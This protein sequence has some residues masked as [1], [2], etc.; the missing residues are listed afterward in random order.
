MSEPLT[1]RDDV[2]P[3]PEQ[4]ARA[5]VA[6]VVERPD[7]DLRPRRAA[8]RRASL[9]PGARARTRASSDGERPAGR[10]RQR[11][12]SPGDLAR[13]RAPRPCSRRALRFVPCRSSA[14]RT[15]ACAR[16]PESR[17]VLTERRIRMVRPLRSGHESARSRRVGRRCRERA[18]LGRPC[19]DPARSRRQG[20]FGP[21]SPTTARLPRSGVWA[22]E[23]SWRHAQGSW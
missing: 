12:L 4:P 18:G 13:T 11:A 8:G 5:A 1:H 14:Y 20:T 21:P 7:R 19:P 16:R 9:R 3:G 23:D 2:H 22:R 15:A 10:R 6:Q 17:A